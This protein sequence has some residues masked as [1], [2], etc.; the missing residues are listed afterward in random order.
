MVVAGKPFTGICRSHKMIVEFAKNTGM[1]YVIIGEDDIKFTHPN[2]WQNYL[3][4]M[5]EEFDIYLGTVSGG[6]IEEGTVADWS[7]MILYT[8]H[9]RFYD[10]F[11]A[12]DENKNIDRWLSG[13][14]LSEVER[15]LGRPPVY[16]IC[17]PIVATCFDGF[18]DNSKK[19]IVHK[20]YFAAYEKYDG[21]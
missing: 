17:Y 18:S 3:D 21:K 1:P 14:G 4:R 7:G 9:S 11:L 10:V 19:E 8:V 12:A 5:P 2:S 16:K 15:R 20:D 13:V 6:R